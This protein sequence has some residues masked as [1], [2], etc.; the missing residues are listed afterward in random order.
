[1][2]PSHPALS[3]TRQCELLGLPRSSYYAG[4]SGPLTPEDLK[5][6]SLIDR[7][8]TKHSFYGSRRIQATLNQA[9]TIVV[10]RKRI[11]RLMRIMGIQ[12]IAPGP[13]TSMPNKENKIYPYLLRNYVISE[14]NQVWSTDITYV[15]L[16]QGFMYLVAV[17]DWF[18]RYI[19]S[20]ELSNTLDSQFCITALKMALQHGSPDIFNTDQ[21]SQFTSNDFTQCLL[22]ENIQ[23][24]MDGKG[25]A[26]DNVFV[27]R[28]W[29]TIKYEDIYL[30]DYDS[31]RSL[32]EGLN[33]F[34]GFYN[35]ERPHQALSYQTPHQIHNG[36]QRSLC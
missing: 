5:L 7:I 11:Q 31:P 23:I 3:I 13:S 36:Y 8:Y 30:K 35:H 12:G 1:M 33:E 17:I 25:R 16:K 28:L 34:I 9:H 32:R 4:D 26:L 21:G 15:P 22:D 18:S 10:N 27:E 20:W 19:L 24:S 2:E 14:S 6:M 29:R